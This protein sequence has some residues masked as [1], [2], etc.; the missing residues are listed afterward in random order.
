M[1]KKIFFGIFILALITINMSEDVLSKQ[2][3]FTLEH[4]IAI[5]SADSETGETYT[6][7]FT[8][9]KSVTTTVYVKLDANGKWVVV[10]AGVEGSVTRTITETWDCC[11][12][13]G[14]GCSKNNPL[15]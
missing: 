14:K 8:K 13:G 2:G 11:A 1:K 7:K 3:A 12:P 5:A 10:S 15:C 4:M 6:D 9:H